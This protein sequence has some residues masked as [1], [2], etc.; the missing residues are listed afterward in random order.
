MVKKINVVCSIYLVLAGLF[1]GLISG[2]ICFD[3]VDSMKVV[4]QVNGVDIKKGEIAE[5]VDARMNGLTLGYIKDKVQSDALGELGI[6]VTAD[7][8][9][10]EF[11][12]QVEEAGGID[13]LE[14]SLI[15]DGYS[16]EQY[17]YNLARTLLSKKATEYFVNKQIVSAEDINNLYNNRMDGNNEIAVM[18]CKTIELTEDE[19]GETLKFDD[20]DQSRAKDET[21]IQTNTVFKMVPAVNSE[22]VTTIDGKQVLVKV[23]EV[24]RGIEDEVVY[25][26]IEN[27][28]KQEGANAEYQEYISEKTKNADIKLMKSNNDSL[29]VGSSEIYGY[30]GDESEISE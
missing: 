24:H 28:L 26:Y 25:K 22:A 27:I 8:L 17:K 19:S 5:Y 30:S 6:T 18:N 15:V 23:T 2:Y 13:S 10:T 20:L 4:G 9:N 16:I 29:D 3:A 12:K 21:N 1:I 14:Q 7:E 11:N